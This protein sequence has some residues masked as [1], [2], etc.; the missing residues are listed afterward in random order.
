MR[1]LSLI[2]KALRVSR[3]P[4]TA[5]VTTEHPHKPGKSKSGNQRVRQRSPV[6][7]QDHRFG[8]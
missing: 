6:G 3:S 4:I 5:R 2:L 1:E 8:A 7:G